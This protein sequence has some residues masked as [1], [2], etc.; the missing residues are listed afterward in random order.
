MNTK[1]ETVFRNTIYKGKILNLRVDIAELPNGKE[2]VREVV[3][4]SGGVTIAALT[5][6]MELI[7]VRQFRYPYMEE[8]LELPAGKLE[9]GEKPLEAGKRELQEEAGVTAEQFINLGRFYPTPGY[10]N[11]VIYLYGAIG[12]KNGEQDLDDDEFLNVETIPLNKAVEMILNNEIVD[13]KTQAAVL[14]LAALLEK[15]AAEYQE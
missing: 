7:F 14:K 1:E 9:K 15:K 6:E 2:A 13:G 4:H 11:E 10:T 3:E 8:V 5:D 12:L